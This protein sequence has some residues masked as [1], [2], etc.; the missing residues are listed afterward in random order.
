MIMDVRYGLALAFNAILVATC[1]FALV[2][3][4]RP[5]RIGA[6]VNLAACGLTATARLMDSAAWAPLHLAVLAID[7]LVVAAFFWL[8]VSTSRFWPIW[9]F[10]FA[11]ADVLM[12]LSGAIIGNVPLFAYQTGLGIYAYFALGALLLGTWRL[13]PNASA[14]QR[15]GSRSPCRHQAQP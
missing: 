10:G 3:G 11:V 8:A 4:G 14:E 15:R 5:E 9:A 12:S 1:G 6:A 13:P 2:R 7:L